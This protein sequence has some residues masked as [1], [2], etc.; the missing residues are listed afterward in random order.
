MQKQPLNAGQQAAA[1]GFFQFLLSDQTELIISGPGGVGKTFLMGYLIDQIIPQYQNTCEL[2]GVPAEYHEVVMTATTNPAVDVLSNNT[3]RP[4]ETIY[5]FLNLTLKPNFNTGEDDLIKSQSWMVHQRK[6]I[7]IDEC[8]MIN[9]ELYKYILEGTCKCKIIYVGDHCQLAPVKERL[10]PIYK[11]NLPFFEL[12]EPMRTT[13][14]ALHSINNQMR[15]TV[16]TGDFG[17]IQLVPGIIDWLDG[18]QMADDIRDN[19]V[20]NTNNCRILVYQNAV[21][22]KYNADIRSERGL[23][24]SYQ[25]GEYLINGSAIRFK[26]S[27]LSI[28]QEVLIYDCSPRTEMIAIEPN[29]EL[30]I[31]NC[32][33]QDSFGQFIYNVQIPVDMGH[34]AALIKF[35]K[36]K[37]NWNRFYFLK[38]NFPDLRQRDTATAYKAQGSSVDTVYID[39]SDI[40]TCRNPDQ[41]AR[42]LYVA[43]SRARKRVVFFGE[44]AE[45]YGHLIQ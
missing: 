20:T 22:K 37:K 24:D 10:S 40:S 35:Y 17:G 23:P 16:E 30:E 21:V 25:K 34:Y 32:T 27:K 29:V 19:F 41:T 36:S 15:N 18:Y 2:M 5:S 26:T 42:L 7:F 8:S 4:A 9:A 6:I 45:K 43:I 14:P 1:D 31:L 12:T 38:N 44:L 28:E 3:G 39:L 33:L 11:Q 13:V